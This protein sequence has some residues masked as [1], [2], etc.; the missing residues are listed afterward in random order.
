MGA[1]R[2]RH[3]PQRSVQET[4]KSLCSDVDNR[5]VLKGIANPKKLLIDWLYAEAICA[6]VFSNIKFDANGLNNHESETR[7]LQ[8]RPFQIFSM[9]Q[10]V[11]ICPGFSKIATELAYE[12]NLK[13]CTIS[14]LPLRKRSGL[15]LAR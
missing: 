4:A 13:C 2:F 3:R 12:A 1:Y 9:K 10:P 14:Q 15:S 7:G 11:A 5:I 8:E 6:Y